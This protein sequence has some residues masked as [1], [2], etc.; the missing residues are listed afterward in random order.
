MTSE[1]ARDLLFK[2]DI[3]FPRGEGGLARCPGCHKEGLREAAGYIRCASGCRRQRLRDAL[4]ALASAGGH[5][6][7]GIGIAEPWEPLPAVPS[8]VR[9]ERAG[10]P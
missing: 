2:L 8:T 4:E 7:S 5:D 9:N 1:D 6:V 3:N 10:A